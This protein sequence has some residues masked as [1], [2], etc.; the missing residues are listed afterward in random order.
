M[1]P[2]ESRVIAAA[3]FRNGSYTE[4]V[5]ILEEL[6]LFSIRNPIS[7]VSLVRRIVLVI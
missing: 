1:N 4:C 7:T 2:D 6:N 3:Y 5:S